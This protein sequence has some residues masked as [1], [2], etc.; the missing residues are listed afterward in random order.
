MGLSRWA[1]A[2]AIVIPMGALQAQSSVRPRA[3]IV[4]PP[5]PADPLELVSGDAQPVTDAA[6]R[7]QIIDLLAKAHRHS[8]V[9][10]Q[11]YDL[12]TTFTVSGSLSAG[13]WQEEDISAGALGYRW[14]VDGPGYSAVNLTVDHLFYSSQQASVLPLRLMQ[15]REAIFRP[16]A[17]VGPLATLRIA[18][19][20]L[21]GVDL[22]CALVAHN[23][24]AAAVAGP[25]RW[26]EQEW[27]VDPKA[28]TLVMFSGTPGSYVHYD[29]S[30]GLQL[31]GKL[32]ANGFTIRQA[33]ETIVE[34][35]TQSVSTPA[36]T[37]DAFQTA[38]LNQR[39]AGAEMSVAPWEF[40][41][42]MPGRTAGV[43]V[44]STQ[45]VTLHAMRSPEG[46]I[47]DAEV[48]ASS[49]PALNA[50]A[51]HFATNVFQGDGA[52][53]GATPQSRE[54]VMILQYT[55]PEATAA[56]Q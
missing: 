25:R 15:V 6:Q 41:T 26:E 10:A 11:P 4:Q 45:V 13:E 9:R 19:A 49:D 23:A 2:L 30:K 5:V 38:G 36:A 39:G 48:L 54:V 52:Q 7:A 21:D 33:G 12:K 47:T 51:L 46:Q 32:I 37:A 42:A 34:A 55:E 14:T 20:S 27:C 53:A 35:Q 44:S 29:Y 18:N 8:N 40:R 56:A 16:R 28:G 22:T 50:A 43:P 17:I 1:A 3:A 31:N 24:H